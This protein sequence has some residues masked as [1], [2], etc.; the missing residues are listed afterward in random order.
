[1]SRCSRKRAASTAPPRCPDAD[2]RAEKNTG[3]NP[4]TSVATRARDARLL[5]PAILTAVAWLAL[6][7]SLAVMTA[8]PVSLNQVQIAQAD[9]V[10]TGIVVDKTAGILQV[11]REWKGCQLPP[12]IVVDNLTGTD[13]LTG[14][15]YLIPLAV[16]GGVYRVAAVPPPAGNRPLVYP[17]TD[18]TR[19]QLQRLLAP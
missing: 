18:E 4:D 2:V 15:K 5:L 1:M 17:A 16:A 3:A 12:A 9:C 6:L 14:G 19:D 8:S 13:A 7:I 10:V 11:V